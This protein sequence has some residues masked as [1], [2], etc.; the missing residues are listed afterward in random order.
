LRIDVCARLAQR[1]HEG[2][3]GDERQRAEEDDEQQRDLLL[4]GE[5]FEL[6]HDW[7]GRNT[8][9]ASRARSRK[10]RFSSPACSCSG[11]PKVT[12]HRIGTGTT[13]PLGITRCTLSIHAGINCT[14]GNASAKW[15]SPLLKSCGSP[16]L[17]RVPSGK[18]T[19]ESPLFSAS[20]S[21][22]QPRDKGQAQAGGLRDDRA[23]GEFNAGSGVCR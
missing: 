15:N 13:S 6:A 9:T 11:A 22:D 1:G 12:L 19:S 4:G 8:T 23:Q 18:M 5:R 14:C 10:A 21:G 3:R 17:L 20:S 2:D 16:L 7:A